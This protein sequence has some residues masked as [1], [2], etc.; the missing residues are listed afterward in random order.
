MDIGLRIPSFT[1]LC[2]F[3]VGHG[4]GAPVAIFFSRSPSGTWNETRRARTR[5]RNFKGFRPEQL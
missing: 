3:D 5:R 1:A 2:R 4:I